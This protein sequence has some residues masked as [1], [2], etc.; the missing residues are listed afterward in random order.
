MGNSE[1]LMNLDIRNFLLDQILI[2]FY[3]PKKAKSA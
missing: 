2:F 3:L 1:T